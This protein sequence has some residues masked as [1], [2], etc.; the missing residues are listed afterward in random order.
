MPSRFKN[1]RTRSRAS[2]RDKINQ[3]LELL[4]EAA[5]DKQQEVYEAIQNKY[6]DIKGVFETAAESGRSALDEIKKS[7]GTVIHSGEERVRKT[8]S[9]VS[10][11]VHESPWWFMGAVAVA[12]FVTGYNLSHGK[13]EH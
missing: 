11:K 10:G 7:A 13:C 2:D 9:N 1:G 4:N 12:A 3:A 5:R 6:E 8:A